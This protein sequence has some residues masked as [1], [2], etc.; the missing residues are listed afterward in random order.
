MIL[1]VGLDIIPVKIIDEIISRL[2]FAAK[3]L[4]SD[5]IQNLLKQILQSYKP[6]KNN[7]NK[8]TSIN[9]T[10]MLLCYLN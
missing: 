10:I 4:D 6:R 5:Q 7:Y 1:I 8:R 2:I 3:A 9:K